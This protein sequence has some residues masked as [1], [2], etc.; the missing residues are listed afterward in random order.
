MQ[1]LQQSILVSD[2]KCLQ[3]KDSAAKELL[4]V[5]KEVKFIRSLL[6]D[7]KVRWGN[8]IKEV[9]IE[10]EKTHETLVE[11][12]ISLRGISNGLDDLNDTVKKLTLSYFDLD[13]LIDTRHNEYKSQFESSKSHNLNQVKANQMNQKRK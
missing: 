10:I 9:K 11:L 7:G 6:E 8:D 5:T 12:K 2:G 13:N 3:A 4:A 1:F